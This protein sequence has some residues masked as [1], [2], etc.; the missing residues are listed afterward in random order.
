MLFIIRN[1]E[2]D[3]FA[4]LASPYRRAPKIGDEPVEEEVLGGNQDLPIAMKYRLLKNTSRDHVGVY[5]LE[6]LKYF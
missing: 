5:R 4:W 6:R 3:M 2:S 1:V